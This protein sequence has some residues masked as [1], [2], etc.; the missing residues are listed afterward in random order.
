[1]AKL[2]R[3]NLPK[4]ELAKLELK[5]YVNELMQQFLARMVEHGNSTSESRKIARNEE[6]EILNSIGVILANQD[7]GRIME[8]H[9]RKS[10]REFYNT[11]ESLTSLEN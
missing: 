10:Q 6:K 5:L 7:R 3:F 8:N 11:V 1:M 2:K 9:W 4:G